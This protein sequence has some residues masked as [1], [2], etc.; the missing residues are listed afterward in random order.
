MSKNEKI[1]TNN[2]STKMTILRKQINK[3]MNLTALKNFEKLPNIDT[4]ISL[5]SSKK[6]YIS[7]KQKF[8][9]N[10]NKGIKRKLSPNNPKNSN[11][12]LNNQKNNV[13][14][15]VIKK[16]NYKKK[17]AMNK[18]KLNKNNKENNLLLGS[19][20]DDNEG[21][22]DNNS[23]LK[24][25]VSNKINQ[26]EKNKSLGNNIFDMGSISHISKN[27]SSSAKE[28][29]GEEEIKNNNPFEK[30]VY[31]F[32]EEEN[33]KNLF[34][35]NKNINNINEINTNE[36]P[37]NAPYKSKAL[38]E[39]LNNENTNRES[40]KDNEEEFTD[41][42][43]KNMISKF[44]DDIMRVSKNE[45][46][47][48]EKFVEEIFKECLSKNY[49]EKT[50]D[51]KCKN[52]VNFVKK[53]V[54]DIFKEC[55]SK[56]LDEHLIE[57][58]YKNEIA[59]IKKFVE[60]IFNECKQKNLEGDLLNE[61]YKNEIALVKKFVEDIFKECKS[62]NLEKNLFNEES[63][64][65]IELVKKFAEDIFIESI[66]KNFVKILFNEIMKGIK[67][68]KAQKE[69][70]SY[71]QINQNNIGNS[72][73]NELNNS[74]ENYIEEEINTGNNSAKKSHFKTL[75]KEKGKNNLLKSQENKNIDSVYKRITT[76]PNVS[77]NFRFGFFKKNSIRREYQQRKYKTLNSENFD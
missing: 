58:K 77:K 53:F 73:N 11:K 31:D 26:K 22:F 5:Y 7:P 60:D 23:K 75:D 71:K 21:M 29:I 47:L 32:V 17:I 49:D 64:N 50:Y 41:E 6:S 13:E 34:Q 3:I 45:V 2:E 36:N 14:K 69:K 40:L 43:Y 56:N 18:Q 39:I 27:G 20:M 70:Y 28:K 33:C 24:N 46:I 65:D 52:E 51:E 48:V 35:E 54:E 1:I 25:Y 57:E 19:L 74:E 30:I 38:N 67:E 59:L 10:K 68:R 62:K 8:V 61:K 63:Q 12:E 44:A 16:C 76:L 15:K 42:I 55:L 37:I 9:I 72:I 4:L 66:A